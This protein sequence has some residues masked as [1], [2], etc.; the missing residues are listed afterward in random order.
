MREQMAALIQ[1]LKVDKFKFKMG[2]LNRST[3]MS[4]CFRVAQTL[5][6]IYNYYVYQGGA[7][8]GIEMGQ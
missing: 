2:V 5:S 7:N 4:M 6:R 8:A 1:R 3:A